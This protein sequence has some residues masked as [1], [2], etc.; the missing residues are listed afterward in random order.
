[1]KKRWSLLGVQSI[2][3]GLIVLA[4]L[5]LYFVGGSA[6]GQL[7][8]AFQSAMNDDALAQAIAQAWDSGD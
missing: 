1:M 6:F 4:V 5:L 7:K 2:L 3:G 8:T